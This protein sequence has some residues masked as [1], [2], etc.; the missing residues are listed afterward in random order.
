MKEIYNDKHNDN[1][2]NEIDFQELFHVLFKKNGL[3]FL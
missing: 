2:N 1:Y 3:L